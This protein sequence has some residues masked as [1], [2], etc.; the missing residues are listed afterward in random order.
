MRENT[1]IG[2]YNHKRHSHYD[3]YRV[4]IPIKIKDMIL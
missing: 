3:D 4:I 1:Q 2:R